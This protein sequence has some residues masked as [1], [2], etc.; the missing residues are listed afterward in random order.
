MTNEQMQQ[1]R[2]RV[3][4]PEHPHYL[5]GGKLTGEVIMLLGKT[6][7]AKLVLDDCKHGGD[8]CFVGKGQIEIDNIVARNSFKTRRRRRAHAREPR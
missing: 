4:D 7:L 5:E 3:C 1:Q 8:A 2:V 6:P